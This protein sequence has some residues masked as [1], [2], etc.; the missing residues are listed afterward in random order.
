M[1][2]VAG[3]VCVP[4][5]AYAYRILQE[6]QQ[7][8]RIPLLLL[9]GC[10]CAVLLFAAMIGVSAFVRFRRA[11]VARSAAGNAAR[12]AMGSATVSAKLARAA[13][14]K[15]WGKEFE[16]TVLALDGTETRLMVSELMRVQQMKSRIAGAIGVPVSKQQLFVE[17]GE[18]KRADRLREHQLG[19][20]STVHLMVQRGDKFRLKSK[21]AAYWH[22]SL[23]QGA[24]LETVAGDSGF[25]CLPVMILNHTFTFSSICFIQRPF[26]GTSVART[27]KH[28]N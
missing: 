14:L 6:H 18:L 9:V 23:V 11:M 15:A 7:P 8:Y 28:G 27:G 24:D 2:A 10:G 16:V 17:Q 26:Y 12:V 25:R 21:G 13:H 1:A 3:I 19:N 22:S 5:L 20:G 4:A